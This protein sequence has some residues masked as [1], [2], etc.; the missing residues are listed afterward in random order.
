MIRNIDTELASKSKIPAPD[1]PTAIG[2]G[3]DSDNLRLLLLCAADWDAMAEIRKEHDRNLRYKNGDQWSDVVE[4]PDHPGRYIREDLLISRKGKVPLKHNYIQQYLRN[5]LGQLL[6]APNQTVVYARSRDD[7][8]LGE[9]LTNALQACHHLNKVSKLDTSIV[10]ELCLAGMACMKVRFDFWSTKNRTDGRLDAVNLHRFFFNRDTEDP[11]LT[12]LRRIGEIHDYTYDEL[13]RNFATSRKDEER[14]SE[15]YG[16]A[17]DRLRLEDTY[18]N[19]SQELE[20]I[21]FLVPADTAKYRVIE[22]WQRLGRWA[23]YVHDYADGTEEIH[24]DLTIAQVEALNAARLEA[25]TAAGLAPEQ[26]RLIYTRQQY[27]YFW[28][29][30]YLT[31]NGYCLREMETPYRHEQHPY[32]LA[33]L[34]MVDG[35]TKSFLSDIIDIQRYINR[36]LTMLDFIIG[37]SAKGLLMVPQEAIPEGMDLRDFAREYAKVNG[38]VLIKKGAS[39]K[40]PRQLAVNA[41]NVGAWELFA[42]EMKIMQ[43]ISGLNNALQGQI[44]RPGTPSSLYAQQTQN[45]AL[46]FKILFESFNTFCEERDEKLLKVLMQYYTT[47][48]YLTIGG[49][50]YDKVAQV[51]EPDM[52]Q[53]IVDFNLHASKSTD[54]PVFRQI[55][56]DMLLELL[57]A[58]QIP[59]EI[60]LNNSSLPFAEKLLA[61]IKTFKEQATAGQIDPAQAASLQRQAEQNADP[62]ALALLERA[63]RG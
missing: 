41:T 9:M 36:L 50:A 51:Y 62:Q 58:G 22:I 37:S 30:K 4:D 27:E 56:D 55:A 20:N 6:S 25:G 34:P 46:N 1:E 11:R 7:Q 18:R 16:A 35:R 61:D 40:L 14:L 63:V 21:S 13:V 47:R 31:P 39:D 57:K 59:L 15:L 43:E 2:S 19:H 24:T 28:Q 38:V 52:A 53:R 54:T 23:L 45:S 60:F 17:R 33:T 42:Q 26:I 32:V 3:F 29:V 49:K 12:D 48:R 10:E 8:P 5:I 44:P